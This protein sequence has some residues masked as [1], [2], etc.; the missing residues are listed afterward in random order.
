[1]AIEQTEGLITV[2]VPTK[3]AGYELNGKI[4]TKSSDRAVWRDCVQYCSDRKVPL[5]TLDQAVEFRHDQN[6]ADESDRWQHTG[7]LLAIVQD[8]KAGLRAHVYEPEMQELERLADRKDI[9][10]GAAY[11]DLARGSKLA[12]QI[13]AFAKKT[14]R[15]FIVPEKDLALSVALHGGQTDYGQHEAVRSLMPVCAEKNTANI[16]SRGYDTGRVWFARPNLQKDQMQVRPV[17]LGG[18][19]YDIDGV[20]A[21]I[22]FGSIGRARGVRPSAQ[23]SSSRNEGSEVV[24]SK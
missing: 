16:K 20:G 11:L 1:M 6:G 10:A 3:E 21:G 13:L 15:T 9:I 24:V 19:D 8:G 23:K 4:W 12:R 18:D 5:Q 22:Q 7:T 2:R 14:G 17:G